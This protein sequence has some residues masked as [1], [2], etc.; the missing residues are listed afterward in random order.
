MKKEI[1]GI[2]LLV[3][4]ILMGYCQNTPPDSIW[5]EIDLNQVVITAQ[6]AP[7]ELRNSL[8]D[9]RVIQAE[10]IQ[11]QGFVTLN[12]LLS[13]ELNLQVDTDPILGNSLRIQGI[14]GENVQIMIDGVPVIGRQGGN[15]DLSQIM[16]TNI[17]R[18]EII[19]GAMSTQ[20][21]SNASGGVINLITQK[22]SANRLDIEAQGLYESVGIV[23]SS[24]TLKSRID[25]FS[26]RVSGGLN[27][28][29]THTDDS[30]RIVEER[31]N[32]DGQAFRARKY[33]WNPKL[34][35]SLEGRLRYDISDSLT[36][37]Y[38][39]RW[40]DEEVNM[41]GEMRR[42]Q[43][44]PYAF[45]Q[46]FFT[47]REDH[48]L[49]L[50]GHLGKKWYVT[51]LLAY[52]QYNRRNQTTRL[53]FDEGTSS[54]LEGE[55][56][57]TIFKTLLHR[58]VLNFAPG[59]R[60][61]F[62]G[63]VEYNREKGSGERIID[64]ANSP[65]DEAV[66]SN[67]AGWTSVQV[68]ASSA[69]Q[70]MAAVRVGY[71]SKFDH[72]VLPSFNALWKPHK[73]WDLRLN[74]ARGFRAPSL[75]ELHLSFIDANHF[76][77]GNTDLAAE[78]SHNASLTITN[79]SASWLGRTW[80]TQLK[81]FYNYISDRIILGAFDPVRFTYL[82]IDQFQTHG[83]S[84]QERIDLSNNLQLNI[85][86]SYTRLYNRLGEESSSPQFNGVFEMRNQLLLSLP[87]PGM[88][89]QINHRFIGKQVQFFVSENDVV[90]E[91]FMGS[92]NLVNASL[93]KDFWKKR[94]GITLGVKNLL[95]AQRVDVLGSAGGV[96]SGA[97]DS[98]LL[99]W[100]RSFFI[101]TRL[102]FSAQ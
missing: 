99:N 8:Y 56:D 92:Y 86:A 70:L 2:Y 72:P 53:N 71:N 14:G 13:Q 73:D 37:R 4:S 94:I 31:I 74:Y 66:I 38:T 93:Q 21:G 97:G 62:Q 16:L 35:Y 42:P 34:Q 46:D 19:Q 100:G 27:Q 75:K 6:Y 83:L 48:N 10:A 96:H 29:Q 90:E 39:Y 58:S 80:Q 23:N 5:D 18:V 61:Q 60:W 3:F 95:N 65:I 101:Q 20:Y 15:I 26:A 47:G 87:Q 78:T 102:L 1:L 28:I 12:E 55:S 40:F 51:S 11:R 85:G 50:E 54:I 32:Q 82:N 57:T 81:F 33:P 91:G 43:Y 88:T 79:H 67:Y 76:I 68:Q 45:D 9:V 7:T 49:Q 17:D 25:R 52:N 98:Q 59:N 63:G 77:L 84:L 69:L 30:L 44:R 22:S 41:L 24:L 89:L 36:L 64:S